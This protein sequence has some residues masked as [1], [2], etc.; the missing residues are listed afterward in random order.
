MRTIP[1]APTRPRPRP[2]LPDRVRRSR[3]RRPPRGSARAARRRVGRGG[4]TRW[5]PYPADADAV[6]D[7]LE[8]HLGHGGPSIPG[9]PSPGAADSAG[10]PWRY[11]GWAR[12]TGRR[13]SG[14]RLSGLGSRPAGPTVR[15]PGLPEHPGGRCR[16]NASNLDGQARNRFVHRDS[17]SW[18]CFFTD[19][20]MEFSVPVK[21]I[22]KLLKESPEGPLR[23]RSRREPRP[24]PPGRRARR[25]G[26]W[27][28]CPRRTRRARSAP[29]TG[30]RAA[31]DH[32]DAAAAAD[33]HVSLEHH[34]WP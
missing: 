6:R 8:G 20:V 15:A 23:R 24:A 4:R 5:T 12:P 9:R 31:G 3:A 26:R 21:R 27:G 1:T 34:A 10:R 22:G 18:M 28:R 13:C 16:Q 25:T 14:W 33:R 19:T 7:R 17:S 32:P 29:L 30:G 2:G 11:A